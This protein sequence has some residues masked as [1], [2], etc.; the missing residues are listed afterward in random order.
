VSSNVFTLR[1]ASK[2]K[3]IV[4][5]ALILTGLFLLGDFIYKTVNNISYVNRERCIIYQLFPKAGALFFEYIIEM[6]IVV[7]WGVF[8]AV[9]LEK[10]FLKYKRF[11]PKNPLS[12]FF[13]A[14]ILPLCACSGIPAVRVMRLRINLKTLVTFIVA[15]PLLNPYIIILSFNVLGIKYTILRILCS[16]ILAVSAGYVLELFKGKSKKVNTENMENCNPASCA[17]KSID[18]FQKTYFIFKSVLIY[19]LIGG[20]IGIFLELFS[21]KAVEIALEAGNSFI[22]NLLIIISG[23][24]FYF[25]HG[26]DVLLLRPLLHSGIGMGTG[27]S[28]SLTSTSICIT[29]IFMLFKFMG[30]KLT[31]LLTGH[32]IIVALLLGQAINL[33]L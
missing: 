22:G 5:T 26:A 19:I 21:S 18:I 1:N 15:A 24:P 33:I 17:I 28:F 3:W 13:Y 32:I 27:L 30:K 6:S 9:L 2:R 10:Y 29:S 20:S 23:I 4:I 12:A 8:I 25:C 31:L 14:S 11:L 7:F 16:F